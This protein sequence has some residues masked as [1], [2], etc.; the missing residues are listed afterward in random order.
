M[1]APLTALSLLANGFLEDFIVSLEKS[2]M[3]SLELLQLCSDALEVLLTL[4]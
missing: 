2:V 3:L 4:C 1:T